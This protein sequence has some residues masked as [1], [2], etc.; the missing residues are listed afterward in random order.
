MYATRDTILRIY[1]QSWL[2]NLLPLDL[3]DAQGA[4]DTALTQATAEIDAYLSA[5][6][7]LPLS[8]VPA[9]L[10]RPCID[11]AAYILANAHSRLTV[12]I[13]DRYKAATALLTQIARG[14]VGLG[15]DEPKLAVGGADPL[16][17][18]S[19]ADFSANPRRF[20][21]GLR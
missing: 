18:A 6:Y 16:G 15:I 21:R 13:E 3:A 14:N 8:R 20:G 17:G 11:V 7:T 10:E 9:A 19:G 5:R 4:V 2:E 12:T 1:G